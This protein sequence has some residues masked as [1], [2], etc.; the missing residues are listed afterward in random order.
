MVAMLPLVNGARN[1]GN[2]HMEF[3]DNGQMLRMLRLEEIA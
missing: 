2:R 1:G 3:I